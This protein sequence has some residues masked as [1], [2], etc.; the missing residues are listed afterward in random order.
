MDPADLVGA[1]L[2]LGDAIGKNRVIDEEL[3]RIDAARFGPVVAY[4]IEE[5]GHSQRIVTRV[6]H[7]RDADSVRLELAA[8]GV[9]DLML[10]HGALARQN[11]AL[12]RIWGAAAGRGSEQHS[13][14]HGGGGHKS[15]VALVDELAHEVALRDVR[16]FGPQYTRQFIL[17]A[18][19]REQSAVNGH[20]TAGDREGVDRWLADDEVIELVLAFLRLARE[21]M[22]NFLRILLDFGVSEDDA[23]LA[24]LVN[25]AQAGVIFIVDGN[26]RVC[27]AA[28]FG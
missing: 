2:R 6:R 12:D 24:Y 20:E 11:S 28:Q 7:G 18:D 19:G 8:A 14:Q 16:R 21:A 25:E 26:R 23:F 13:R 1:I 15:L 9:V 22:A 10:N 5:T 4:V 27:G 3:H 17:V